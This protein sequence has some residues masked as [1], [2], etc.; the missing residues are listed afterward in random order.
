M[1][2]LNYLQINFSVEEIEQEMLIAY[3]DLLNFDAF[4]QSSNEVKAFIEKSALNMEEVNSICQKLQIKSPTISQ[5]QDKNWNEEWE[6]NF[7]D[8]KIDNQIHVRASFH[9]RDESFPIEIII[10]PKM[11]FGT[12]SHA[13]TFQVMQAMLKEDFNNKSVIDIGSGTGILA[14]LSE[15][16]GASSILAIDYDHWCVTN[17]EEN[18]KLNHSNIQL[19]Q[20]DVL[21]KNDL[22]NLVAENKYDFILANLNRN[23]LDATF[24][25]LK[26]LLKDNTCLI[27]SGYYQEDTEIIKKSVENNLS[28]KCVNQLTKNNWTVNIFKK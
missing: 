10:E 15:K 1:D 24:P 9:N 7:P 11:S 20:C 14:I 19:A 3:L 22:L 18:K 16:L 12:G 2:S 17:M 4:E 8:S 28:L 13:T 23:L 5:I 21:K 26:S 6:K 27:T 25:Q